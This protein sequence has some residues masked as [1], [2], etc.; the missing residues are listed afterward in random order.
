MCKFL[1]FS[2]QVSIAARHI[3][4]FLA[5]SQLSDWIT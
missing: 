2:A 4:V 3:I 5:Y 1:C